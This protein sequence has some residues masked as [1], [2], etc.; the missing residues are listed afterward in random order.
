MPCAQTDDHTGKSKASAKALNIFF[1][2]ASD[3]VQSMA[4]LKWR[5]TK[6]F[7]RGNCP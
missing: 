2:M 4:A 6:F 3:S 5:T 7:N 1:I